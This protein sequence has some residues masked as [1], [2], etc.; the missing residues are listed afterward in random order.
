MS[1]G[2]NIRSFH[3]NSTSVYVT[4]KLSLSLGRTYIGMWKLSMYKLVSLGYLYNQEVET[5]CF[6]GKFTLDIPKLQFLYEPDL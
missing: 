1:S 2:Q 3:G 5:G 6:R 4:N